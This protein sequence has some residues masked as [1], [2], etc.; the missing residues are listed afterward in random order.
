MLQAQDSC[1]SFCLAYVLT[2]QGLQAYTY[3]L[4][5]IYTLGIKNFARFRERMCNLLTISL[6]SPKRVGLQ[7]FLTFFVLQ[8]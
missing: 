5:C 7:L 8:T 6:T 3:F 4:L 2:T 1:L